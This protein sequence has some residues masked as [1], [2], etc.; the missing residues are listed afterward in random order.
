MFV[1]GPVV[2]ALWFQ[3]ASPPELFAQLWSAGAVLLKTLCC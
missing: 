2:A 3:P 1:L